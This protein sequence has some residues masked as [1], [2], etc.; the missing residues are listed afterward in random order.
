MATYEITD[1][2]GA[3]YEVTAPDDATE[4]QILAS[5]AQFSA[6]ETSAPRGRSP[7]LDN[8]FLENLGAGIGNGF[9]ERGL[10]V[11]QAMYDVAK[12]ANMVDAYPELEAAIQDERKTMATREKGTGVGGAIGEFIG[13]PLGLATLPIGGISAGA[14]NAVAVAAGKKA[15]LGGA[16]RRVAEMAARRAATRAL[17][18]SSAKLGAGMGAAQNAVG[19]QESDSLEDRGVN[20][21]KGA[22]AGGALGA[23]LIGGGALVRGGAKSAQEAAGHII[24]G[25]KQ[26]G[27][28]D[29]IARR[30]V[31]FDEAG[32]LFDQALNNNTPLS[33][34]GASSLISDIQGVLAKEPLHP[35]LHAETQTVVNRIADMANKGV[36][37]TTRL[38]QELKALTKIPGEDGARAGQ[39]KGAILDT[40]GAPGAVDG[41]PLAVDL[42]NQARAQF[43]KASRFKD[44]SAPLIAAKGDANI[45]K[46]RL[47]TFLTADK[48]R[49]SAGNLQ[50]EEL[51]LVSQAADNSGGETALK[52][53]GRFG[54]DP[55]TVGRNARVPLMAQMATYGAGGGIAAAPFTGGMSMVAALPVAIGTGAN[56]LK[57]IVAKG[58]FEDA[59][60]A[61]ERRNVVPRARPTPPAPAPLALPA[62]GYRAPMTDSQIEE[63][64]AVMAA[65]LKPKGT[66]GGK[67]FEDSTKKA[68]SGVP[69][70]YGDVPYNY[71]GAE[72]PPP[73][74]A[75]PAPG[76]VYPPS[77]PEIIAAAGAP[78]RLSTGEELAASMRLRQAAEAEK[79]AMQNMPRAA[80]AQSPAPAPAAA[81]VAAAPVAAAAPAAQQPAMSDSGQAL[82]AAFE[83]AKLARRKRPI[84]RITVTPDDALPEPQVDLPT[85]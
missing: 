16:S 22:I 53:M 21:V 58:K 38:N 6:P 37:D 43:T 36:L 35:T 20:V 8:S 7:N 73:P 47:A 83:Q 3:V 66:V 32:R 78:G 49:K 42:I 14:L 60:Q 11:F 31:L 2:S 61:I 51:D 1:A 4:E 69:K 71:I 68:L 59:L 39:I 23:G 12:S 70:D 57:N 48:T 74:L 40:L 65:A 5:V 82:A 77:S 13:D 19:A 28:D 85:R 81:P 29:V 63:A 84:N 75:L 50:R 52:I 46:S 64:R 79:Q 44:V 27:V 55:G 24:S 17:M 45:A 76:T 41:P 72:G 15:L 30:G 26:G 25:V 80:I 33:A 18:L 56:Y 34:K 67:P 62:P 9:R 10:G 54:V